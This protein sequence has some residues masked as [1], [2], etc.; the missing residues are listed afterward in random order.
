MKILAI[1]IS[2]LGLFAF[3]PASENPCAI[4]QDDDGKFYYNE[5]VQVPDV[6]KDELFK[7]AKTWLDANYVNVNQKLNKDEIGDQVVELDGFYRLMGKDKKGASTLDA[8]IKYK[9]KILFKDGRYRYEFYKFH[10][11]KGFYF[12]LEKW[13][14]PKTLD[15]AMAEDRC[16]RVHEHFTTLIAD[17]KNEIADPTVNEEDNW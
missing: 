14:D 1:L 16:A 4:P 5:V 13:L 7:R 10:I 9:L 6:S 2:A 11:D 12:P 15:P 17:M 8:V 3:A